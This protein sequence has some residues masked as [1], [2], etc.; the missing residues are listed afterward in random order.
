M[1]CCADLFVVAP[2]LL[3]D[4]DAIWLKETPA[5]T[6]LLSFVAPPVTH[7]RSTYDMQI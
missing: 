7:V 6:H 4:S 3:D 2:W 1:L 5:F